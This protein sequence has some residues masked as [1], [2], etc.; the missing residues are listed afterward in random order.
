MLAE[1]DDRDN[2]C[3]LLN[4]SRYTLPERKSPAG[5]G[6]QGLSKVSCVDPREDREDPRGPPLADSS[7]GSARRA[8]K[9]PSGVSSRRC[10][11]GARRGGLET[12]VLQDRNCPP[13]CA[14]IVQFPTL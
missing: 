4:P 3:A 1:N 8:P 9:A 11:K 6:E 12:E 13:K 5:K 7:T 14:F 2:E 10:T